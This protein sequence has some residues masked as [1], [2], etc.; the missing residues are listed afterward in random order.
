MEFLKLILGDEL[1]QAVS[2]KVMAF[3]NDPQNK[4]KQINI[5]NLGNGDYVS[6]RKFSDLETKYTSKINELE[7]ANN[8]IN[9]FK[10]NAINDEQFKTKIGEYENTIKELENT[11]KKNSI[12][13]ALKVALLNAKVTDV[14]YIAYKLKQQGELELD[15]KGDIKDLDHKVTDLKIKYPT[16]FEGAGLKT[17]DVNKLPQNN[18]DKEVLTK[19]TILKKSYAERNA[20]FEQD[21]EA[22]KKIMNS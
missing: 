14:D 22:Y 11:L 6:K 8:L 21:P 18:S 12:D 15:D 19:Q 20:L 3:N 13:N 10:A 4:D 2:D 16:F 17:I 9:D 7:Q 1:Y 5:A